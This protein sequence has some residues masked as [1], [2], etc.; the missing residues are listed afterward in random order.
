MRWV[1]GGALI[2]ALMCVL[3]GCVDNA[4]SSPDSDVPLASEHQ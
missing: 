2:L 1:Y 4:N 3:R